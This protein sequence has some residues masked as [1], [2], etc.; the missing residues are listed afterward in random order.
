MKASTN[1]FININTA[2]LS[3]IDEEMEIQGRDRE[4]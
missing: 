2:C 3:E 4:I 1:Y